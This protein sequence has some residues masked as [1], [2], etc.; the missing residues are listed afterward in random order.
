MTDTYGKV[1]KKKPKKSEK[2]RSHRLVDTDADG[3]IVD[4]SVCVWDSYETLPLYL[5][6]CYISLPAASRNPRIHSRAT[7]TVGGNDDEHLAQSAHDR[8]MSPSFPPCGGLLLGCT[9]TTVR[10][11]TPLPPYHCYPHHAVVCTA[12]SEPPRSPFLRTPLSSLPQLLARPTRAFAPVK[13]KTGAAQEEQEVGG[14]SEERAGGGG[15]EE[16]GK[17]GGKERCLWAGQDAASVFPPRRFRRV[18]T[19]ALLRPLLSS[20]LCLLESTTL[21]SFLFSRFFSLF[22]ANESSV[23]Y[24]ELVRFL[25]ATKGVDVR[26]RASLILGWNAAIWKVCFRVWNR[27]IFS[28]SRL[29]DSRNFQRFL[30]ESEISHSFLSLENVLK[31]R[32]IIPYFSS[33]YIIHIT[34]RKLGENM[35]NC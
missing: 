26:W 31:N 20:P 23:S 4:A 5:S 30:D 27:S 15:R 18:F 29:A 6:P 28:H 32:L 25:R 21:S 19:P 22:P 17:S 14:G 3:Y 7:Y 8:S 35:T 13:E 2:E 1:R 34:W 9:A 11:S 16:A 10:R 33:F 24:V 12:H